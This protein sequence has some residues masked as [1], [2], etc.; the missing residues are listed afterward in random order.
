[1]NIILIVI[2]IGIIT[3]AVATIR[4][5]IEEEKNWELN[6]QREYRKTTSLKPRKLPFI[7]KELPEVAVCLKYMGCIDS[8][9]KAQRQ[10]GNVYMVNGNYYVYGTNRKWEELASC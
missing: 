1:M 8:I 4:K 5:R 6:Y 10:V 2:V 7:P 9:E 3:L